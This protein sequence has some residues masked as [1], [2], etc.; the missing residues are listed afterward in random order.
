MEQLLEK[1][2]SGDAETLM[3]IKGFGKKTVDSLF[4]ELSDPQ[5]RE[6]IARLESLGLNFS[7]AASET[8]E[9]L[10][11][12]FDGQVWCVT[13]S[14]ERFAP[15]SLALKEIEARGGRTTS[16][17]TSKTSHLL[18]GSG[19]GSKLQQARS[20]GTIVVDEEQFVRML[21]GGESYGSR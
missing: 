17:V 16:S 9:K 11:Q 1:V 15:R 10:P 14:F 8:E 20:L 12:I 6:R 18:A 5:V 13:G 19:A 21:E 3:A 2:D 4:A 7:E